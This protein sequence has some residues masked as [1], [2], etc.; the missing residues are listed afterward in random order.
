MN[1]NEMNPNV[2]K[3]HGFKEMP[4]E[5][6]GICYRKKSYEP[7]FIIDSGD[8]WS[9]LTPEH[10]V[11]GSVVNTDDLKKS[12]DMAKMVRKALRRFNNK[13]K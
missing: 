9:I 4:H 13:K 12:Y 5:M 1:T 2:L 10:H 8:E 11:L 6:F 3:S 7:L